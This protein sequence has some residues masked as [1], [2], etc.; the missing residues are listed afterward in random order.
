[1][2]WTLGVLRNGPSRELIFTSSPL[3]CRIIL[4]DHKCIFSIYIIYDIEKVQIIEIL[5]HE[6]R[7]SV[8][9][10]HSVVNTMHACTD[11]MRCKVARIS[12]VKLFIYQVLPKYSG[13]S[14]H[15]DGF[16]HTGTLLTCSPE[17]RHPW[18]RH[19]IDTLSALLALCDGNSLVTG[20]FPSQRP[21]MQS[22]VVF[23]DLRPNKRLSKQYAGDL[24]RH[25]AHYNATVMY[26]TLCGHW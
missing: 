25:Y 20:E 6:R 8:Y 7:W 17:I 21:V 4:S 3:T 13:I 18:W 5:H 9:P 16:L 23:F 11:D 14:Q 2:W 12:T 19:K 24:R 22:F 10:I 26:L 1:M 15:Q